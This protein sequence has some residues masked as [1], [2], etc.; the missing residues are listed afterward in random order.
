V[1]VCVIGGVAALVVYHYWPRTQEFGQIAV[2]PPSN[3]VSSAPKEAAA[4]TGGA[5]SGNTSEVTAPVKKYNAAKT[6]Q[7]PTPANFTLDSGKGCGSQS[8]PTVPFDGTTKFFDNSGK[9]MAQ[10]VTQPDLNN[11]TKISFECPKA[12][13][14]T[15]TI[16][17][18]FDGN[19]DHFPLGE[20]I[21]S[22]ERHI[23]E[24]D[25]FIELENEGKPSSEKQ[26]FKWDLT[27]PLGFSAGTCQVLAANG[28]P[29]NFQ[30]Q[31]DGTDL[32]A[33][34]LFSHALPELTDRGFAVDY[35]RSSQ[36]AQ[37]YFDRNF[38]IRVTISASA[39][40]VES[41]P[42]PRRARP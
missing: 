40:I 25:P 29:R 22:V 20:V 21:E 36:A 11:V 7:K 3:A 33:T 26:A 39:L 34:L 28:G 15:I 6:G 18:Y 2:N 10:P 42:G 23:R 35:G 16:K 17:E 1:A 32:E 9:A 24:H 31:Y 37:V 8:P 19:Q 41:I 5:P 12:I 30:C 4:K 14:T 38:R 27:K 13:A